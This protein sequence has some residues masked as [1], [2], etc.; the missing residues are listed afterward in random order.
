MNETTPNISS[1][2]ANSDIVQNTLRNVHNNVILLADLQEQASCLNNPENVAMLQAL[3]SRSRKSVVDHV[4]RV[5]KKGSNDFISNYV[6][7]YGHE[8]IAECGSTS[9]FFENVSLLAANHLQDFALY[10]GIECSTR[11]IDFSSVPVYIPSALYDCTIQGIDLQAIDLYQESLALYMFVYENVY[12]DL[13]ISSPQSSDKAIKAAAY[14]VSRGFLPAGITT[15]LSMSGSLSTLK[16]WLIECCCSR[17]YEVRLLSFCAL[18][19]LHEKYPATFSDY[20]ERIDKL[21]KYKK[22]IAYM[23]V[24]YYTDLLT[25]MYENKVKH[26]VVMDKNLKEDVLYS[27]DE[28]AKTQQF[29]YSCKN[30]SR[31]MDCFMMLPKHIRMHPHEHSLLKNETRQKLTYLRNAYRLGDMFSFRFMLDFG[32]FRDLHRHRRGH[33]MT[34]ILTTMHGFSE[35]Y[36]CRLPRPIISTVK[37]HLAQYEQSLDSFMKRFDSDKLVRKALKESLGVDTALK[38]TDEEYYSS[39]ELYEVETLKQIYQNH[40]VDPDVMYDVA[41]DPIRQYF[42]LLGYR[43]PVQ[44]VCDLTQLLYILELRSSETVHFSLRGLVSCMHRYITTQFPELRK[45]IHVDDSLHDVMDGLFSNG[46]DNATTNTVSEKRGQ[47]DIQEVDS[48]NNI[49]NI[50]P[51]MDNSEFDRITDS[52][53]GFIKAPTGD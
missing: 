29:Y 46:S 16:S 26:M 2:A 50:S 43:V 41:N 14:D 21:G 15:N 52:I 18:R 48:V 39:T 44:Y 45:T 23:D 30:A 10:S 35:I 34:P 28:F 3:Y 31:C 36:L 5:Q 12:N 49:K 20:A 6:I 38:N 25:S 42:V 19:K 37:K 9:I 17:I 24:E 22:S 53:T 40:S 8:S 4:D 51:V 32:S 33:C 27:T 1:I 7:G 13:L 47:Q 11:Y